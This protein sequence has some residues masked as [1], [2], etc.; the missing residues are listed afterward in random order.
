MEISLPPD[1]AENIAESFAGRGPR[2]L[3][4]LPGVVERLCAV[5]GL[6]VVGAS[7]GGGTHSWV[8]PVRRADGSVAVLKVPVVDEEN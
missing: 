3:A 2:W 4:A 8:A 1:V 5:W 6:E 7:F